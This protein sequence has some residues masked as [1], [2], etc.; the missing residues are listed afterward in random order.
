MNLTSAQRDVLVSLSDGS[1]SDDRGGFHGQF[2][3]NVLARLDYMGLI[4]SELN[5]GRYDARN[6]MITSL[7][8][9]A[10]EATA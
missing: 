1:W 4:R 2:S 6:W 7:G 8:S 9:H 5:H 10:L 3:A